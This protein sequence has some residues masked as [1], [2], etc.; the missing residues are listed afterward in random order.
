MPRGF[1][2]NLERSWRGRLQEF[3]RSGL[4]VREYCRSQAI[5]EH[6][7]FWWRRESAINCTTGS[8]GAVMPNRPC[9]IADHSRVA[10]VGAHVVVWD[11]R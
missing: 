4:S 6:T 7:F 11:V 8:P 5:Q 9:S 2:L 3:Q 1:D 10:V